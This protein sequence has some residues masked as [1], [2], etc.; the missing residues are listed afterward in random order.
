M[1]V[2]IK[3][4]RTAQH[5]LKGKYLYCE[6]ESESVKAARDEF[7]EMVGDI[8]KCGFWTLHV[9]TPVELAKELTDG[10]GY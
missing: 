10:N 4:Y 8:S 9:T 2:E 6:L 7:Y 5:Y 3:A 1:R